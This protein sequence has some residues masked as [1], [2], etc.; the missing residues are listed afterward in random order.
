[1]YIKV[2]IVVILLVG[3][4]FS[5]AMSSS[6]EN[7]Q[8]QKSKLIIKLSYS[9]SVSNWNILIIKGNILNQKG[10]NRGNKIGNSSMC[11]NNQIFRS[12]KCRNVETI[13]SH[14]SPVVFIKSYENN[15]NKLHQNFKIKSQ[16]FTSNTIIIPMNNHPQNLES[17]PPNLL[18]NS[19]FMAQFSSSSS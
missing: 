6:D 7:D 19:H 14:L 12:G 15:N 4:C 8:R 10:K 17:K 1:M 18:M 16:D 2:L 5:L 9:V 3:I 11:S 13:Q